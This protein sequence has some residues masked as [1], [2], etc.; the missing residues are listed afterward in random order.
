MYVI[1]FHVTLS[2][3]SESIKLDPLLEKACGDD[4]KDLCAKVKAGEAQVIDCLKHHKKKLTK[5]CRKKIFKRQQ[6]EAFFGDYDFLHVCKQMIKTYCRPD[7]PVPEMLQVR[8]FLLLSLLNFEAL[9][10][11][12]GNFSFVSMFNL[13]P[14]MNKSFKLIVC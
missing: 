5:Q 14:K 11:S 4:I 7:S 2:P 1:M 3:Q 13:L 12:A 9:T 10:H 8:V 6:E